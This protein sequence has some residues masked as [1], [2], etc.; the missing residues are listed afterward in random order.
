MVHG[1]ASQALLRFRHS[2]REP[3]ATVL[4]PYHAIQVCLNLVFG[5]FRYSSGVFFFF[6]LLR[7]RPETRAMKTS[8]R[9]EGGGIRPHS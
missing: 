2:I 6:E 5:P 9:G 7:G 4:R 3:F 1:A 8:Y